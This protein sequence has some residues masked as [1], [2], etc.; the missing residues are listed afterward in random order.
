MTALKDGG[1]AADLFGVIAETV[2]TLV[3][4][5][6]R[7]TA[8][9]PARWHAVEVHRAPAEVGGACELTLCGVLARV[10]TDAPWPADALDACPVCAALT[11]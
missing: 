6:S 4:A 1:G 8:A 11:R 5:R 10:T 9:A 7:A 3:A 2:L